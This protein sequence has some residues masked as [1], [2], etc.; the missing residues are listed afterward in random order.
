M[1]HSNKSGLTQEQD[2]PMQRGKDTAS[3]ERRERIIIS[4]LANPNH[5]PNNDA[6]RHMKHTGYLASGHSTVGQARSIEA[7]IL[8]GEAD[9][10]FGEERILP[11]IDWQ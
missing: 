9:F 3:A 5:V 6:V 1:E 2:Y 7:Y 11:E 10:N 8:W 4:L